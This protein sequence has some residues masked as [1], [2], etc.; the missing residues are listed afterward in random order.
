MN[1]ADALRAVASGIA[2]ALAAIPAAWA[3]GNTNSFY[4]TLGADYSSGTYGQSSSTTIWDVP[5]SAGYDSRLWSFRV[6]LPYLHVSGPPNVIPGI[7]AIRN[8]NPIGRGL[9]RL[10]HGTGVTP[11]AQT[12]TSTSGTASGIGDVVAQATFHAIR[13]NASQFELDVTGRIE[14]G[15][16]S[17]NKGLGT[18][19]NNYGAEVNAY[20]GFGSVWT[21]FGGLGYTSLGSSTYI[22]LRNVWSA[23]A[24]V[25]YAMD[26][27]D[28][29]GFFLF[30][31][32]RPSIYGYS[33]Q[34]ATFYY[35]HKIN[36]TWALQGYFLGGF[37]NGSPD[38]GL[39]ASARYTF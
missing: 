12:V 15:T 13:D 27:S 19:Q 30:F 11:P 17:A 29:A 38:Y 25:N 8:N 20:K 9:G 24:G 18:G 5:L 7:G 35:N 16:A 1:S 33:R 31:Q 6:T 36:R 14:F 39:G 21:L 34:E 22:Q 4:A 10:L 2:L 28:S 37:A 3:A 26:A 23:N 32:Q